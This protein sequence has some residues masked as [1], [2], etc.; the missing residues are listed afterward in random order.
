MVVQSV[1][2]VAPLPTVALGLATVI[3]AIIAFLVFRSA[4]DS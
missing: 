4:N 2:L 3:G 1:G